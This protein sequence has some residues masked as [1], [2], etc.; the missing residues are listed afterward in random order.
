[1][2]ERVVLVV[3]KK[4]KASQN[5]PQAGIQ[6]RVGRIVLPHASVTAGICLAVSIMS[7]L[8]RTPWEGQCTLC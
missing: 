4:S 2:A 8:S 5:T 3:E 7:V 1:M 6:R